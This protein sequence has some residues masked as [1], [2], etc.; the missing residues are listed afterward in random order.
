MNHRPSASASVGG[1]LVPALA[2]ELEHGLRPQAAVE[3]VVQQD[4]GGQADLVAAAEQSTRGILRTP[5]ARSA[6]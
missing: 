5:A 3:V 1:Q 6:P 4:L 2:R